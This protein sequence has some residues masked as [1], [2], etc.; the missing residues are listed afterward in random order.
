MKEFLNIVSKQS[1]D[2]RQNIKGLLPVKE[3]RYIHVKSS[4]IELPKQTQIKKMTQ[5]YVFHNVRSHQ[6]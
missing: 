5:S 4:C 2:S 3:K 1:I 6:N